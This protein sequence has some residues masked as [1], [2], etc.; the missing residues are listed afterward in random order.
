MVDMF[1]RNLTIVGGFCAVN[2]GLWFYQIVG[3]I[4]LVRKLA[5]LGTERKSR[6]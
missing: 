6:I 4:I 1:E 2:C 3:G 5:I